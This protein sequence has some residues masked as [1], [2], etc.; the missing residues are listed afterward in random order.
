M[1]LDP[2]PGGAPG[3]LP[4]VAVTAL[5][6]FNF[7][8]TKKLRASTYG[9]GIWEFTLAEGPDFQFTSPDNVLTAFAGQNAAFSVSLLALDNFNSQVNLTCIRARPGSA[10][11]AFLH[12]D[13]GREDSNCFRRHLHSECLRSGR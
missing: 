11:A 7:G 3:F 5:R 9:R 1:K 12:G 13:A 4:N 8:G 10:G 2:P 6:M